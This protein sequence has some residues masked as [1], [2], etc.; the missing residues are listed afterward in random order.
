VIGFGL[1]EV[2]SATYLLCGGDYSW[3]A[4]RWA[5]VLFFPGFVA[6]YQVYEGTKY[7]LSTAEVIGCLTV[8]VSYALLAAGLAYIVRLIQKRRTAS[9][10]Q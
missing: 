7:S 8:G 2:A 4:P 5:S 3:F 6:G 1:G 9:K 10:E